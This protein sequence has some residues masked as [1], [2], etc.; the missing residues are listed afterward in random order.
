MAMIRLNGCHNWFR[1][2]KKG[3]MLCGIGMPPDGQLPRH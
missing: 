1:L 2:H 3:R